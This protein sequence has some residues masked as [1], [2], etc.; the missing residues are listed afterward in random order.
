MARNDTVTRIL[1]VIHLLEVN[2]QGLTIKE[3]K[4][5][6][7]DLKF[8]S[9]ERTIYRDL[10]AI[11][12]I[13][14][15]LV[16][17]EN[18]DQPRWKLESI[19]T[20]NQKI[21][22]SYQ[23]L[24]ALFLSK[25]SMNAFVGSPIYVVIDSFFSR[26]EKVLGLAAQKEMSK[27][28]TYLGFKS[29]ASWQSSVN[30]EI[31]DTIYDAC[32]EGH[33]LELTYKAKSGDNKDKVSVRNLGP[34]GLYFADAG[35]YLIGKDLEK[36][37]FRTFSLNRII[38]VKLLETAY[39]SELD[40]KTY[41]KTSIGLL[42]SGLVKP[43]EIMITDPIASYVSE[44]RWHDSQTVTRVADGIIL[45][46]NVSIN[47]ELVR[48]ILGLGQSAIVNSPVELITMIESETERI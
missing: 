44:R 23:E 20:V 41:L 33:Q 4:A 45:R 35:A 14:L 31:I 8:V 48:W 36:N 39:D 13:Q 47:D 32:A 17:N 24:I 25:E 19:A 46:L 28:Q 29:K 5:K 22:F 1:K 7:D 37:E 11:Q 26:I 3:I 40:L 15:P 12:M 9:S 16:K 2:P 6:L 21:Q 34:E 43:V 42:N 18:S 27:I 38:E 30:Q 10:E